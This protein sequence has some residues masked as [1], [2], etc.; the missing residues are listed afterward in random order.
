M[1]LYIITRCQHDIRDSI[2]LLITTNILFSININLSDREAQPLLQLKARQGIRTLTVTSV[3]A[4][5]DE[6]ETVFF[7]LFVFD[8]NAFGQVYYSGDFEAR[9]FGV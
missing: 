1:R 2:I 9:E 5:V 8:L 7:L 4:D 3:E 6:F